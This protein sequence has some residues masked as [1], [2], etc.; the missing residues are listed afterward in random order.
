MKKI[1]TLAL[2]VLMIVSAFTF[3]IPASAQDNGVLFSF[4]Y[5]E[6]CNGVVD[7]KKTAVTE[8]VTVDGEKALQIV[9]TP[10]TAL[11]NELR[12]DCWTL[13]YTSAEIK[14]AKYMTIK[15]RYDGPKDLTKP[16]T[17]MFLKGGGAFTDFVTVRAS[18]PVKTGNWNVAV[19]DLSA[20]NGKI[21]DD[22]TFKQF[23][24]WPYGQDAYSKELASTQ[25]MYISDIAFYS[26]MPDTSKINL[27]VAKDKPTVAVQDTPAPAETTTPAASAI[28]DAKADDKGVIAVLDY[29]EKNKGIADKKQTASVEKV[30]IDG[31]KALKVVPTP[32]TAQVKEV[33]LD[34]FGLTYSS[35]ELKGTKYLTVKYKYENTSD[36]N[37]KM[38]IQFFTGGGGLSKSVSAE[39]TD[40]VKVG[41]WNYAL[42]DMT[43]FNN[44]LVEGT[45]AQFHFWPFGGLNAETL[46]PNQTLYLAD[47]TFYN[48]APDIAGIKLPGQASTTTTTTKPATTVPAGTMKADENG[49]LFSFNYQ[50]KNNGVVDG[51]K[52]AKLEKVE[53]DGRKA[54]KVIP[55][56]S[57]ALESQIRLDCYS[58]NY[59][60]YDVAD[61]RFLAVHYKYEGDNALGQMGIRILGGTFLNSAYDSSSS[62]KITA[63]DWQVAIFDV[64]KIKSM[65]K[66]G[67]GIFKQFHFYPYGSGASVQTMDENDVI[68]IADFEFYTLNPDKD[69]VY[70]ASFKKGHP[71]AMGEDPAVI[72]GKRGEKFV[73]PQHN[74]EIGE[75]AFLG[76]KSTEDGKLYQPGQEYTFPD[77]DVVFNAEF[78]TADFLAD[79][80]ALKFTDFQN[81]PCDRRD[82]LTVTNDIFQNKDVVKVCP[83][84]TG[85]DISKGA[86]VDGYSYG[87]AG[88]D[89]NVYKYL[90]IT[91]YF[92]GELPYDGYIYANMLKNGNILTKSYG[93]KSEQPISTGRWNFASFDFSGIDSVLVP[94]LS[95]HI[96]KQMHIYPFHSLNLTDLKGT[97]KMYI[98]NLLFFKEKPDLHIEESYMKGYDGGIF[99]P[100]GNMTR[101]EACTI[102][103]RLS[104]G[105][106][107]LVPADKTTSFTDVPA[108]Q[109]YHKYVSY[110]ESL[111]YLKG[112]SGAFNPNQPITR[113][114]F[115]ELVYNMGLLKDA[116]KNGT[117]TDVAADH[118][119]AAVISAAGK[120]GLV[121]GYDN[122]DGTF[123]FKPDNTIT[124][125]EVVKVINNA[126][127][128]SITKKQLSSDVRYSFNDVPT[129]FWAYA[130]IL[131]A[132]LAHVQ[133]KNGWVFC[134]VSPYSIFNKDNSTLDYAA[135]EAYLKELDAMSAK[136]IEEVRNTPNM[137][138]SNF[139]GKKIYVS[140]SAGF[141]TNDGLTEATPVK[142]ISAANKLAKMGDVILLKRGDLW[143]ERF[144]AVGGAT[145]TAY[146]EGA[147]PTIYGSPE[148]GTGA[149]NWTLM[150][151]TTNIWV[152]K[153]QLI[154]VGGIICDNGKVI[155]LKEVPDLV[156]GTFYVRGTKQ[157]T[158]FDIKT[159]LNEN[160]EF[161]SYVT[162]ATDL[163][164]TKGTLY[165]RCDEGNPGALFSQI[166]FN[167]KGNVIAN[168][169][170][171]STFDNLCIMYT[172]THGIGSGTTKNLTVTNCEIAWI[173]GT[174]QHYNSGKAVRLG[175]GIEI[176]G[177]CDGYLVENN[178]IWQCYDA[179]ATHQ[180]SSGG[181]TN[182][183]MYNATYKDNIIEDCIYNIE[184]F[185]GSPDN[186]T[187][188]RDGKNFY[189]TNNILRRAGYGWGNQRPDTNTCAHIKSW[190]HRNE[191]ERG[192]YVIEGN[193]FDRAMW[194]LTETRADYASWCPIYKNNTYIQYVDGGLVAHKNLNLN[195]DCYAEQAIK[196]D[197]GDENAKVYFL[198]E[199]YK[200][201][202]FLKR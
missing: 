172:G 5:Q 180:F 112:Y 200:H 82:C 74:Y 35:A 177:G 186:N 174:L 51:K 38:K 147:K 111:G 123:S 191:Y 110:V 130:D 142:S 173:G 89:L 26:Q 96:L 134:M 129:D 171:N 151:G 18:A 23:H 143:R 11:V 187:V 131:E 164:N 108:D 119:K 92:D 192:T 122:G 32:S 34:C 138:L 128:R 137:D 125:A 184:Y 55:S 91:Y 154:D 60:K 118:P 99:K 178:Y 40:V 59:N 169:G 16:M 150:E 70:L 36:L 163:A 159:H 50:E 148:N 21:A 71:D 10:S 181:T 81:G 132:T 145:Y 80:K 135:G 1:I 2:A 197:L 195:Y 155:G 126:Y 63:G 87:P 31:V 52:T 9:P 69:A 75:A 39:A 133:N 124:R 73:L 14:Q 68:Y 58:L 140:A 141:D 136:K 15:Y 104:A 83:V 53:I 103:A 77:G 25:T 88:I 201:T 86:I 66:S 24:L 62:K 93:V 17:V 76:W 30:E 3:V 12:L 54:L 188:T 57:T 117:F 98:A 67:E 176:Y 105:S 8:K 109:W 121:N 28:P 37:A 168:G 101:A 156:N 49:L 20:T 85:N 7:N 161:F 47:F 179:G 167:I 44:A 189:I 65:L 84:P 13:N 194:K 42:F 175:N 114:E 196:F 102:V 78:D 127:G 152:Y 162:N 115:V 33:R 157:Q 45:V 27:P 56:P 190:T 100:Q 97:E 185:T 146:G 90:V 106:D 139:T 43:A 107:E 116:G 166:E 48:K 61:A 64:S 79:Y 4:N 160:Y 193:I 153:N 182:I 22:A 183:S 41:G 72:K 202:G 149:E 94:D 113:A 19:F 198:P 158:P 95:T 199:S 165:F 144:K 6:K 120:A 29:P 170:A 46:S